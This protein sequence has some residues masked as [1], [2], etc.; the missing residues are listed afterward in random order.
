[1]MYT[2]RYDEYVRRNSK[3]YDVTDD[4]NVYVNISTIVA[5]VANNIAILRYRG[6]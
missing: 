1:L 4:M 6:S 5:R 2:Y 3:L